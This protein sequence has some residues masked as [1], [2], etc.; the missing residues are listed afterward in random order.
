MP[1]QS[2]RPEKQAAVIR[3]LVAA[4]LIVSGYALAVA[5]TG[6]FT[7]TVGSTRLR[8]HSWVR[9]AVLAG[10]LLLIL[11]ARAAVAEW[12]GR[13]SRLLDSPHAAK[14]IALLAATWALAAGLGFNTFAT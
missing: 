3:A 13:A 6:G 5:L 1:S 12:L 4:V 11:G 7:F 9:P 2:A 8:S 10:A 14:C